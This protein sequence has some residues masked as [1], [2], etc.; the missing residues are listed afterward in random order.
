VSGRVLDN[1][2]STPIP[3][4]F[5]RTE[6][7]SQQVATD[8]QG[9][10]VISANVDVGETYRIYAEKTGYR[11]NSTNVYVREGE[12]T[13]ADIS[14]E[15]EREGSIFGTVN[16]VVT[17]LPISDAL[18]YTMPSSIQVLTSPDGL[19]S[20]QAGLQGGTR[21]DVI[22]T[23]DGYEP[24]R[25]SVI[26][27]EGEQ[28]SVDVGLAPL[29]PI[30]EVFPSS[31]SFGASRESHQLTLRNIGHGRLTYQVNDPT[32]AWLMLRNDPTGVVVDTPMVITLDINRTGI[33][34]GEHQTEIYITSN[35][36]DVVVPIQMSVLG[37]NEPR[38]SVSPLSLAFGSET[39]VLNVMLQNRGTGTLTW[40]IF[41]TL[42]WLSIEPTL[43]E[44][45]GEEDI[46][47]IMVE[48]DGVP[49]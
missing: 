7:P 13:V 38:V 36:G 11:T 47:Q 32:A 40:Q 19:Y 5:I 39:Q 46:V 23:K 20:I 16:D 28:F 35:G 34:R 1:S 29:S 9:A 31:V 12:N 27:E 41:S 14:L 15:A 17:G 24:S 30:L 49:G 48:W 37:E 6:P 2:S 43:G 8:E 44:T 4:A 25:A 45:T 18:V 10:F 22:A 3:R 33:A 42:P 21:Y 26:F